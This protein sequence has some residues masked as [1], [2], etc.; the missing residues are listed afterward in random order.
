MTKL[1]EVYVCENCG[2]MVEVL[3]AGGG[4]LVCCNQPMTLAAEN[5]TDAAQ[6]KHVP[7]VSRGEGKVVA[8]VG[9]VA[10][11]M[12]EEH[13]IEWVEILHGDKTHRESL[14]PGGAPEA[15][16]DCSGGEVTARAYCNLHGLWKSEG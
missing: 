9:S 10:H 14:S 4:T 7:V 5:T 16:F 12:Q 15:T 6:E 3:R 8:K 1:R 2:N 11:P 13:Y